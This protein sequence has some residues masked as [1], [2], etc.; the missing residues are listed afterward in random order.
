MTDHL[1]G[2][3]QLV[4]DELTKMNEEENLDRMYK[5]FGAHKNSTQAEIRA[6][7]IS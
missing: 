5:Q 3:N 1:F 7:Y 6:T 4:V 2:N